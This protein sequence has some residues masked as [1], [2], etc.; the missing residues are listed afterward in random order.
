C[1][2]EARAYSQTGIGETLS[3]PDSHETGQGPHDIHDHNWGTTTM[4]SLLHHWIWGR[5]A[6]GPYTA[7]YASEY[8]NQPYSHGRTDGL[9]QFF[10]ASEREVLVNVEG[11]GA[12]RVA[13]VPAVNP[14]PRNASA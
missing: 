1:F 2:F 7:V 8:P 9:Q 5:A 4:G 10:I 3:G 11:P 14:D 12:A 13:A 6:I